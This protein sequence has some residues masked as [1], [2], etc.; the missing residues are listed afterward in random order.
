M[1]KLPYAEGTW[2]AVP[3]KAG[4]FGVGVVARASR[5]GKIIL[6]YFFGPKRMAVATLG[7]VE[8]LK[9]VDAVLKLRV[10]DLGLIRGDWPIIGRSES[11]T[12]SE[13]SMPVFIRR[14]PL[15]RPKAWLVH[16]S[17][18]DPSKPLAEEPTSPR[19]TGFE[20]DGLDGVGSAEIILTKTLTQGGGRN[21]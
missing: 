19:A 5:S 18:D 20:E 7:E 3:L 11:W 9:P 21:G 1:R 6:A 16:Y 4:G 2:F 8:L 13:F 14:A 12:R 17:D 10:G 15:G